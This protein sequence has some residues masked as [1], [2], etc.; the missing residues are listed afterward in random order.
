MAPLR[1]GSPAT[2][3][4]REKGRRS[5]WR[6][7][8]AVAPLSLQKLHRPLVTEIAGDVGCGLAA[9]VLEVER[10]AML[11]ERLDR[12]IDVVNASGRIIARRPHQR[13]EVVGI[14]AVH[15]DSGLKK[16]RDNRGGAVARG[17]EGARW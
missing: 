3:S 13:R 10:G 9:V 11:D 16:K 5:R 4:R 12:G 17:R 2:F 1:R 7:D 8:Q 15:V 6:Y 14:A